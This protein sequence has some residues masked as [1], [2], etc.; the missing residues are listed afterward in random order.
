ML[1]IVVMLRFTAAVV[2]LLGWVLPGLVVT[3]A[4]AALGAVALLGLINALVWPVLL[5]S[6]CR[7][8]S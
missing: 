4:G 6:H 8:P 2:V 7:W 3:S 5:I 1:R